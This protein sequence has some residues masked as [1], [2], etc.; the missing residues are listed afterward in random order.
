MLHRSHAVAQ[1]VEIAPLNVYHAFR[2]MA[3]QTLIRIEELNVVARGVPSRREI[4]HQISFDMGA[5]GITAV[6]GES[7]SGKTI[8]SRAL[9]NLFPSDK[10]MRVEGTVTF[11][12]SNLLAL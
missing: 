2:D 12:G 6:I 9:T 4:L 11:D 8:L 7:G 3:E 10:S 1:R 5:A